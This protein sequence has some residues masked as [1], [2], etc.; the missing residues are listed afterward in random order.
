MYKSNLLKS[1]VSQGLESSGYGF[2]IELKYRALKKTSRVKQIPIVFVDRRHGS[3]KIPKN[4][5]FKNFILVPKLRK[6]N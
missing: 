4:T 3:S 1:I 2:L 6:K 5:I